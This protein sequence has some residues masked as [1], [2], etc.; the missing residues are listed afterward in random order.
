M[1]E[2]LAQ[3][4]P[5]RAGIRKVAHASG[6]SVST[7]SRA[8]NG[9]TD[10]NAETRRRIEAV[11]EAMGYQ[12]NYAASMLRR[13]TT[14]TVTFV[15]SQPWGKYADPF[16]LGV[17]D[18]LE[19]ALTAQ[20]YDL[21]VVMARDA[22]REEE[23]THRIV[24]RNRSDAVIFARTRPED[25]RVDW[26]EE[27][28][29]PFVTLGQTARNSHCFVD[30][31]QFRIGREAVA[32]FV[33]LGHVDIGFLATPMI[34]TYTRHTLKGIEDGML[35]AGLD[36]GSMQQIECTVGGRTGADAVTEL[37]TRGKLPTALICGNDVIAISAM[38]G[39]KRL[40]LR[41]G[42]DVALI[43]SDDAPISAHVRPA[44]T[45]FSQDL[46]AMGL[47]LGRLVLARLGGDPT[48]YHEIIKP[49][50]IVRESDC[51]PAVPHEA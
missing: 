46:S 29:M 42:H 22:K 38:E 44:L 19:M 34:Y 2:E 39:L 30:R 47:R 37:F 14:Q 23:F 20:D 26:L 51:L 24:E 21:Q 1:T 4:R 25:E 13:N 16:F 12:P 8:L 31:D 11:A 10:V 7:V 9:Y 48:I 32:R 49:Q 3:I 40:G 41:P 33:A 36:P 43:G 18:G 15:V 50:L 28:G 45:T 5:I 6:F 17:L 27:R 35:A